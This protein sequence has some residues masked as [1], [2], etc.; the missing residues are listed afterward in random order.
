MATA[1]HIAMNALPFNVHY[2]YKVFPVSCYIM[3]LYLVFLA[4][5][6]STDKVYAVCSVHVTCGTEVT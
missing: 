2:G 5:I 1:S 6:P 4:Q 3:C